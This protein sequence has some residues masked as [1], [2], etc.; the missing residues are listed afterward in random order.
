MIIAKIISSLLLLLKGYLGYL[1]LIEKLDAFY[2]VFIISPIFSF[3]FYWL[4]RSIIRNKSWR[5]TLIVLDFCVP[6][7]GVLSVVLTFALS[8]FFKYSSSEKG[9]SESFYL[10]DFEKNIV[11]KQNNIEFAQIESLKDKEV[12]Y[13]QPYLDIFN[14]R[15][16]D[17]KID[18]C[19]KLSSFDDPSSVKL[20][21]VAL[22]D[23][24]YDV[25]Y[26][27]NNALDKIEKKFMLELEQLSKLIAKY[28]E[29]IENYLSRSEVYSQLYSTGILDQTISKFFLTKSLKD[30]QFVRTHQP[31]NF[32]VYMKLAHIHTQ[33]G[34]FEELLNIADTA[35]SLNIDEN[36][37]NKM[38]FFRA[39]ALF[40][41]R[42]FEM[43]TQTV[44]L[45]NL[46]KVKY[47]KILNSSIYWR[48]IIEP[49]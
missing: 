30:L 22:Q 29:T 16:V 49:A 41:L 26:M 33:L 42:K 20:L 10:K 37:A 40:A 13:I 5:L 34:Q 19:I 2:Y 12:N 24:Q 28:P 14:G 32:F 43:L 27:A 15:N 47:E 6:F 38:L 21:K 3:V 46:K 48:G 45:I 8:I 7:Y 11:T 18:A 31:E 4:L 39:E 44:K 1:F 23:D 35:L 25:R 17:L 36:E 9:D